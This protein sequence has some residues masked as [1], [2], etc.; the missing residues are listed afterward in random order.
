MRQGSETE[1]GA[2]EVADLLARCSQLAGL[3]LDFVQAGLLDPPPPDSPGSQVRHH[4][5]DAFHQC[6]MET[7]AHPLPADHHNRDDHKNLQ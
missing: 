4:P 6:S 2:E 1:A 5:A 3:L 7:C